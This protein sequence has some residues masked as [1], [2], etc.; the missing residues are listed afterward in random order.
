MI[1][2][3]LH[4]ISREVLKMTEEEKKKL[5]EGADVLVHSAK[6]TAGNV[7]NGA[8]KFYEESEFSDPE[9]RKGLAEKA[10]KGFKG[11][12]TKIGKGLESLGQD[13]ADTDEQAQA[14]EQNKTDEQADALPEQEG[15]EE[16]EETGDENMERALAEAAKVPVT[17]TEAEVEV[18]PFTDEDTEL[19]I[20][21]EQD[22]ES[23]EP[24]KQDEINKMVEEWFDSLPDTEPQAEE[25]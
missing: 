15:Q 24:D 1:R 13:K 21:T 23:K 10:K 6:E 2:G 7:V 12:L 19:G 4:K 16:K 5:Q 9:Y 25:G 17:A 20:D 22:A 18:F 3:S 11:F 14:Q 8:K